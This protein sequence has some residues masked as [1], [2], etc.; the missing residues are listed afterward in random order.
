MTFFGDYR[1]RAADS[2]AQ[3]VHGHG[4]HD[5]GDPHES[6]MLMLVPL[7]ILAVLSF[8]GGWIGFH[9]HF[10]QFLAPVFHAVTA[11]RR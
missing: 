1:G 7:M 4:D 6:P 8:C 3:P 9:G 11:E 10:E 2:H 5:H